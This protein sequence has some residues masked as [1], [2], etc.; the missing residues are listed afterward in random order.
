M[1]IRSR[2]YHGGRA[3]G[4][5]SFVLFLLLVCGGCATVDSKLA[6]EMVSIPGGT[7]RMGDLSGEGDD[8]ELPVHSVTVPAFRLGK[9][10][11]TVGQFR[12]FVE[13]TGYRTEAERYGG[14]VT[15]SAGDGWDLRAGSSWR[16]PGFFSIG[17]GHPAVC[18]SWDDAQAY[19]EWLSAE[20][21]SGY[22]LP[23]EAEWEY[24][25]RA[26]TTTE[27]SWGNDIGSN[28]ANCDG[29]GSRWDDVRTAP[30]GSF[31]ANAWGLHDMHG[32]VKEWVQD[33]WNDSY[34][35][36][37]SDGSAWESGV[38]GQRVRRGGSWDYS[39]GHVR[40]AFRDWF[41]RA[42]H[43]DS[44]S[45]F[46]LASRSD[47]DYV[48]V[49]HGDEIF[50]SD[51]RLIQPS[52]S[53][54]DQD[55]V[56][57]THDDVF[58]WADHRVRWKSREFE[59]YRMRIERY[60]VCDEDFLRPL[61]V[62]VRGTLVKAAVYADD[63]LQVGPEQLTRIPSV[64]SLFDS[65]LSAYFGEAGPHHSKGNQADVSWNADYGYP[66]YV[67]FGDS[68]HIVI[69]DSYISYRVE[70]LEKIHETDNRHSDAD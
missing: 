6:G 9:H 69:D 60:C 50:R 14:C 49:P 21:G 12:R 57:V 4:H 23:T 58:E 3:A 67:A 19:V 35:G 18:V 15:Y 44:T 8:D 56:L 2:F 33:C 24:A 42:Y 32:N 48:V 1:N 43:V 16:N 59:G 66:E 52:G 5:Y 11:V 70:L 41:D 55:Y 62:E 26:G 27:Y 64:D 31:P 13:A 68:V 63:G 25:A 30:V 37:P 54:S 34:D 22:R 51:F 45:G 61:I 20:T 38:C 40:S 10:E 29:C 39:A 36:A 7:F 53:H 46:R 65:I 28:Q 47:Q 17:D